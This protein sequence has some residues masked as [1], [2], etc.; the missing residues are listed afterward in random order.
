[1]EPALELYSTA[2]SSQ[3]ATL[4]PPQRCWESSN[5]KQPAEPRKE[6]G[7]SVALGSTQLEDGRS[8][9]S[10]GA[11]VGGSGGDP[12]SQR[13][14]SGQQA[15]PTLL[16]T[17]GS[18]SNGSITRESNNSD[19]FPQLVY[20]CPLPPPVSVFATA[21]GSPFEA[22]AP[23][24]LDTHQQIAHSAK[25]Q[26]M[27]VRSR[28]VGGG[29]GGGSRSGGHRISRQRSAKGGY[30]NAMF[31]REKGRTSLDYGMSREQVRDLTLSIPSLSPRGFEIAGMSLLI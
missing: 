9:I 26:Q 6:G 24:P 7:H 20:P 23:H 22:S 19:T 12:T 5:G 29:G 3:I 8:L 18:L 16:S 1:M 11:V 4:T 21:N 27:I 15:Y 10:N 28:S 13:V 25:V 30:C 17:P 14:F 2:S 31:I